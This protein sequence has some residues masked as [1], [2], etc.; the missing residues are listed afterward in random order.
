[1]GSAR[2][3]TGNGPDSSNQANHDEDD[4]PSN[5]GAFQITFAMLRLRR[6][7]QSQEITDRH[8]TAKRQNQPYQKV[9]AEKHLEAPQTDRGL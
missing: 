3:E 6:A 2:Y 7:H 1:M 4:A 9:L 5:R 8:R